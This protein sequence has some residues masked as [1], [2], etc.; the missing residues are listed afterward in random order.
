M[1]GPGDD[2]SIS[3]SLYIVHFLELRGGGM[4]D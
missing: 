2:I 3:L 1:I 4:G